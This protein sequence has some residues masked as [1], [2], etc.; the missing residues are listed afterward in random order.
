MTTSS[1]TNMKKLKIVE[2]DLRWLGLFQHIKKIIIDSGYF[3]EIWKIEDLTMKITNDL[4]S[5]EH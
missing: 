5:Y 3:E 4:L 2:D 1:K